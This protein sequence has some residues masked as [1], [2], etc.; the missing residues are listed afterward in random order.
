MG[1]VFGY[2]LIF[3]RASIPSS[4]PVLRDYLQTPSRRFDMEGFPRPPSSV[5]STK[6]GF[7]QSSGS[8]SLSLFFTFGTK[9]IGNARRAYLLL[10]PLGT[11]EKLRPGMK[12]FLK[13]DT[14]L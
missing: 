9:Q 1:Y 2:W 6:E 12:D 10:P 11:F 4:G 5:L 7:V 3:C 8:C 13:G 14:A